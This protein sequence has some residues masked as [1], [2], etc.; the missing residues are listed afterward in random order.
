LN[1]GELFFLVTMNCHPRNYPNR[2]Q[3]LRRVGTIVAT[4]ASAGLSGCSNGNSEDG[5]LVTI[6]EHGREDD[7]FFVEI[8]N[9]HPVQE[10]DVTVVLELLD[11]SDTVVARMK[12]DVTIDSGTSRRIEIEVRPE[13]VDG[14]LEAV[15]SY[16]FELEGELTE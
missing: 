9:G 4:G 16:T 11:E 1:Y 3:Y 6:Q 12:R 13:D 10:A 5:G 14:N 7:L 8:K 15:E 2:R